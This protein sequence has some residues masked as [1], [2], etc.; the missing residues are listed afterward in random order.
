MSDILE[1]I[2][3]KNF[4]YNDIHNTFEQSAPYEPMRNKSLV[5]FIIN[6]DDNSRKNLI[7]KLLEPIITNKNTNNNWSLFL[8]K[9]YILL[10][11]EKDANLDTTKINFLEGFD[12]NKIS[13]TLQMQI[14]K[15]KVKSNG[16]HHSLLV[17]DNCLTNEKCNNSIL[18][19]ITLNGRCYH[20]GLI[21]G[22]ETP[23]NFNPAIR[24]NTDLIFIFNTKNITVL[25]KIYM[26]YCGIFPTFEIFIQILRTYA[27][28]SNQCLV[29]DNT[30]QSNSISDCV[31]YL[32]V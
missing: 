23:L 28:N 25:S 11:E 19:N 29:I 16:I 6:N 10:N 32:E 12:E 30:I 20:Y 3:L 1:Y 21:I 31:F 8:P 22:M 9:D 17:L 18:R 13:E 2:K 27:P 4:K 5:I 26:Q 7:K 24:C 15:K 14:E